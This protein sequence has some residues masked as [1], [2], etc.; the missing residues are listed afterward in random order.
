MAGEMLLENFGIDHPVLQFETR[1]C[2]RGE[3]LCR[4]TNCN[5]GS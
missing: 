4:K 2:G 5:G 3:L 1:T